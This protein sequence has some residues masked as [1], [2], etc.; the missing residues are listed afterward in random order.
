MTILR[1]ALDVPLATLFDY[2]D[3]DSGVLVGQRVLVPFGRRRVIGIVMARTD[4]SEFAG[5]ASNPSSTLCR[6]GPLPAATLRLLKF[7]ANYYPLS[8]RANHAGGAALPVAPE[9]SGE[10]AQTPPPTG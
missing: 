8:C 5:A 7:C 10:P 6:R 9:R 2:R 4:A 3:T 1:V